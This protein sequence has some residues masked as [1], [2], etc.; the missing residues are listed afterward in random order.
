MSNAESVRRILKPLGIFTAFKPRHAL[1]TLLSRPTPNEIVINPSSKPLTKE[2]ESLLSKGMNFAPT[3]TKIPCKEI[4]AE[5]EDQLRFVKNPT[6]VNLARNRFLNVISKKWEAPP[7]NLTAGERNAMK[8][9]QADSDIIVLP[10]DKGKSTVV[11]D[12][13]EYLQKMHNLVDDE[14][15]FTKLESDPTTR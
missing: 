4:I 10:S 5:V 1:R 3:T 2:Q 12:R 6:A 11:L 15:R 14:S 9:L 7:S 8:K 13:T